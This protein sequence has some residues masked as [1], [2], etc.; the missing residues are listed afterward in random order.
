MHTAS[1]FSG[2]LCSDSSVFLITEKPPLQCSRQCNTN[3]PTGTS[4]NETASVRDRRKRSSPASY[5]EFVHCE[6]KRAAKVLEAEITPDIL[7]GITC[8]Y[9]KDR[10]KMAKLD[11][12]GPWIK[13]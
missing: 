2:S 3:I 4:N 7:S 13:V 12:G 6:S 8:R 10:Q 9:Q 5:D 1:E 11:A